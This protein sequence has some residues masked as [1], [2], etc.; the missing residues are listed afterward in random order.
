MLTSQLKDVL[1]IKFPRHKGAFKVLLTIADILK[2]IGSANSYTVYVAIC[3]IIFMAVMNEIVKPYAAKRCKFPLPSEL[4]AVVGFTLISYI[5]NLGGDFGVKEVGEIPTGLPHP[6]APPFELLKLVAVDSIAVT[7]VSYS[8]V[9]SMGMIFAQKE[10]YEVRPNQELLALGL[11]NIVG[12]FFS[13]IPLSCSLSRSVIQHQAGGKTQMASV[14]SAGIILIG[15]I[16]NLY[17][18]NDRINLLSIFYP[19]Q[20]FCGSVQFLR[21]FHALLWL[22][23][24]SS[25]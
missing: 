23:L 3:C 22:E 4:M 9:M 2:N 15:D 11:S 24:S 20:C 7:I 19:F 21:V 14:F 25:P 5:L 16:S 1:G 8:V 10:Q 13:C 12:S 6:H 18:F 17:E